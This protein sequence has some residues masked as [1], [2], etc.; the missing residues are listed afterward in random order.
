MVV[1]S[2]TTLLDEVMPETEIWSVHVS[3]HPASLGTQVLGVVRAG[4]APVVSAISPACGEYEALR[5]GYEGLRDL[6]AIQAPSLEDFITHGFEG[7]HEAVRVNLHTHLACKVPVASRIHGHTSRQMVKSCG[8]LDPD[9]GIVRI[10]GTLRAAVPLEA[11]AHMVAVAAIMADNG[12]ARV[13]T[14]WVEPGEFRTDQHAFMQLVD[15]LTWHDFHAG[16]R[17][18]PIT[19]AGA[20]RVLAQAHANPLIRIAMATLV[21]KLPG[22]TSAMDKEQA[23]LRDTFNGLVKGTRCSSIADCED[24]IVRA[25]SLWTWITAAEEWR[26]AKIEAMRKLGERI[27]AE[28]VV[29]EI[30]TVAAKVA[31]ATG[32]QALPHGAVGSMVAEIRSLIERAADKDELAHAVGGGNAGQLACVGLLRH[33]GTDRQ[34]FVVAAE[35]NESPAAATLTMIRESME[36][37]TRLPI[38][39]SSYMHA[40]VAVIAQNRE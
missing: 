32:M 15:H 34:Q 29:S 31:L 20:M 3:N 17:D 40:A 8:T 4:A 16:V 22:Q 13:E 11:A 6:N 1:H 5:H 18:K 37:G 39:S 27:S 7:A 38:V 28:R 25:S 36:M 9:P 2:R 10:K 35:R 14:H 33:A 21:G 23:Y 12:T 19:I 24:V 30:G 26:I